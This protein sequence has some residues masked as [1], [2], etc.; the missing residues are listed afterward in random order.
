MARPS[1]RHL[2]ASCTAATRHPA[3]HR[4]STLPGEP[5]SGH[6]CTTSEKYSIKPLRGHTK[7][8]SL[9]DISL[10]LLK[11]P[12]KTI[13]PIYPYFRQVLAPLFLI[14]SRP[15]RRKTGGPQP[16]NMAFLLE[17]PGLP[18]PSLSAPDGVGNQHR[19]QSHGRLPRR[20]AAAAAFKESG[21]FRERNQLP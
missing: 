4:P 3:G 15:V 16:G 10:I 21:G 8:R 14:E 12:A 13:T 5:A 20:H 7:N 19:P 17:F 18:G 6:Q 9:R 2:A 11:L 1:E